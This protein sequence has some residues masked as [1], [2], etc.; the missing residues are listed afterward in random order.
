MIIHCHICENTWVEIDQPE[1]AIIEDP[2]YRCIACNEYLEEHE[3]TRVLT[4][5]NINILDIINCGS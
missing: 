3:P 5:E 2:I 1:D 4:K